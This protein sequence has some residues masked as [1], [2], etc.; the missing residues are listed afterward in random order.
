MYFLQ[1]LVRFRDDVPT[2]GTH[3]AYLS[4]LLPFLKMR[5]IL[6]TLA[7]V[8]KKRES[9]RNQYTRNKNKGKT[10]HP[11]FLLESVVFGKADPSVL[12]GTPFELP[13][14][15]VE[16]DEDM[17][18]HLVVDLIKYSGRKCAYVPSN[19]LFSLSSRECATV[20]QPL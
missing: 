9:L 16:G 18:K 8:K 14:E 2:S 20:C 1:L 5:R 17:D 19:K 15:E 6:V 4:T 7:D 11:L 13:P 3:D 12:K 10:D